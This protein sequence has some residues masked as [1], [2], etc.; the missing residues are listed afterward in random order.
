MLLLS[1]IAQIL[2]EVYGPTVLP[3][4]TLVR[5]SHPML[6]ELELLARCY[7]RA[8]QTPATN[9]DYLAMLAAGILERLGV[10]RVEHCPAT[11]VVCFCAPTT[12]A[13]Y[14]RWF[15]RLTELTQHHLGQAI[16]RNYWLLTRP[17]DPWLCTIPV[18]TF[19]QPMAEGYGAN[20]YLNPQQQSLLQQWLEQFII[21]CSRILP[22]LPHEAAAA[23]VP[24][25]R[26]LFSALGQ[27]VSC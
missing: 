13:D 12:L 7:Q 10:S 22:T 25:P 9:P 17:R 6:D 14:L 11:P 23:G 19:Y 26:E 4:P 2:Q 5:L 15:N 1:T 3:H 21:H 24:L 27:Q 16:V 8:K 20:R 18:A